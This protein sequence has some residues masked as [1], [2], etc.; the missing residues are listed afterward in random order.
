MDWLLILIDNDLQTSYQSPTPLPCRWWAASQWWPSVAGC[1]SSTLHWTD[2]LHHRCSE[3]DRSAETDSLLWTGTVSGTSP[4]SAS[5]ARNAPEHRW[6]T[7]MPQFTHITME[8]NKNHQQPNDCHKPIKSVITG[9]EHRYYP[10]GH[11]QQ[12]GLHVRSQAAGQELSGSPSGQQLENPW[13][14]RRRA[15]AHI[16]AHI[17]IHIHAHTQVLPLNWGLWVV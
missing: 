17:N 6:W 1:L 10:G 13:H 3:S 2:G 4:D 5:A 7:V 15:H 9:S 11:K 8:S 16:H 12:L 14:T